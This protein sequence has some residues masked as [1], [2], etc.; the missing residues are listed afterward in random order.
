MVTSW[1]S[2][3][4][5]TWLGWGGYIL[6]VTFVFVGLW[7][8]L[9]RMDNFPN[10]SFERLLGVALLFINLVTWMGLAGSG[11]RVGSAIHAGLVSALGT[12]GAII[13]LIA[14]LLA[15]LIFL[16]DLSMADLILWL[17]DKFKHSQSSFAEFLRRKASEQQSDRG[18]R[19]GN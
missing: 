11:G 2:E 16:V 4:L 19:I 14:W 6:P 12:V 9:S 8:L 13:L 15:A 10:I 3:R 1:I 7:F 5:T 17:A 18:Y